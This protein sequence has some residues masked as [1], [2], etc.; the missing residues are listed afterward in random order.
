MALDVET[1]NLACYCGTGFG[2]DLDRSGENGKRGAVGKTVGGE[3]RSL[4]LLTQDR[5]PCFSSFLGRSNP[6]SPQLV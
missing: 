4:S 3:P 6:D 1:S 2:T 5:R